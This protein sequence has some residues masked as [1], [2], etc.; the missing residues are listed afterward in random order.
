VH[1]RLALVPVSRYGQEGEPIPFCVSLDD[2]CSTPAA[3]APIVPAPRPLAKDPSSC[4]TDLEVEALRVRGDDG[5]VAAARDLR[6]HYADC[7][8]DAEHAWRWARAAA[9]LGDRESA[10][11]ALDAAMASDVGWRISDAPSQAEEW[12][13]LEWFEARYPEAAVRDRAD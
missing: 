2:W 3:Q 13:L 9:D 6:R 7:L 5:S 4:R 10:Q 1:W 8:G 11:F 12:H